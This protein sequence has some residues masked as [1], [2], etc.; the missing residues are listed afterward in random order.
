M[1][2]VISTYYSNEAICRLLMCVHRT[3]VTVNNTATSTVLTEIVFA[4][5]VL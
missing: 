3:H 1:S 2:C 4:A 5:P